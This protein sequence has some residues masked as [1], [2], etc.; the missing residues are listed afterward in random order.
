VEIAGKIRRPNEPSKSGNFRKTK[1]RQQSRIEGLQAPELR[2]LSSTSHEKKNGSLTAEVILPDDAMQTRTVCLWLVMQ[3]VIS[4]RAVPRV[5]GVVAAWG[6]AWPSWVLHFSSVIS[7]T[8]RL[9]LALLDHVKPMDKPWLAI[10]D[11]SL[12]VGIQKVLVVY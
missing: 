11:H 7:W 3:A 6:S 4:F 10:I 8:L 9:G 5:L 12:A 2:P 1:A